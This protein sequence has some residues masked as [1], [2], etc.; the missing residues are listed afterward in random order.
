[1]VDLL[2]EDAAHHRASVLQRD[3]G[4]VRDRLEKRLVVGRE[5]RV[6]IADELADL[7]ALPAQR[8]PHRVCARATLGPRDLPVLEHER[9]ARGVQGLHR[10][11]HDRLERLLEVQ[12]LRDGLRDPGERL[13]LCDAPL[14]ALVELRV[15]D[16]LRDLGRDRDEELDLGLGE[17]AW[18]ARTD[19]ERALQLVG[20]SD[21]RHGED[22]L[23]LVLRK[24]RELLEARVEVR[25]LGDHDGRAL[26]RCDARDPL[27]RAHPWRARQL[28][29]AR[30]VRRTQH[31]LVGAFVVEVD[32][33]GVGAERVGHLA[34]DELEHLLQIERRVDRGNRL[35]QEPQVTGGGIHR[36]HC[37]R[38]S[39][40]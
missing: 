13:Q 21:D 9:R 33:T 37:H 15:L 11:L 35:G 12:G 16:R 31:E 22:R 4:V 17:R 6:A 32:E 19:V 36:A 24:V 29:H 23:V 10:R 34:R 7:A 1:M 38:I 30:A 39:H 18:L 40:A 14:S 5:R 2:S 3:C 26:G 20:A 25:L 28:L 8:H 27:S